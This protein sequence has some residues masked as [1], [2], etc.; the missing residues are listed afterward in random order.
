M[1]T[2]SIV[3]ALVVVLG[4]A[5][6][7]GA[8][9]KSYTTHDYSACLAGYSFGFTDGHAYVNGYGRLEQPWQKIHLGPFGSHNVPF[10]ATQG[11]V[12]FCIIIVGLIA[13]PV[14]VTLRWKKKRAT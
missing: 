3:L 9:Y 4:F 14:M 12:G 10:T 6:E 7:A 11:L 1:R 13:L 5:R 8:E 2:A